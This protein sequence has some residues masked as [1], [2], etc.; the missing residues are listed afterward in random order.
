MAK[1]TQRRHVPPSRLRYEQSHPTIA[2]RVSKDIYSQ[3]VEIR[4]KT[5]QSWADLMKVALKLQE[6]VMEP[7]KAKPEEL[8]KARR[9]GY[10][11]GWKE[12]TTKFQVT[13][14]CSGCGKPIE[15]SSPG[16]KE[17]AAKYMR[18]H[19]WSHRGCLH[20]G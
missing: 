19:N 7:R 11:V 6:P 14:A 13:Y 3:L 12:A 17:A 15:L 9:E 18:E 4:E 16:E 20:K 8:K 5:G 1:S 2:I 10:Q